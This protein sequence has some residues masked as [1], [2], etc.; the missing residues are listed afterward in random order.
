MSHEEIMSRL[1][2]RIAGGWRRTLDLLYPPSCPLCLAATAEHDALCARCW[3]A[4]PLLER[5]YCERLGL[6]FPVDLGGP[7][8][9]VEAMSNPPV[10]QRARAAVRYEGGARALAH[11]LK[12][13]D[14]TELA[15]LLA[16]MMMRAGQD[17]MRDAD[18]IVPVPLHFGRLWARRFNQAAT[19][20]AE[21][22]R[23]G[24]VPWEPLLLERRKRTRPQVGLSRAARA[25]N[26]QG[27]FAV[28]TRRAPA[29]EG[30]RVLLVDDVLTT[31]ATANACARALLR[32]GARDVD[33]LVF[34][35]VVL[36]G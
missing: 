6:P 14:R 29:L 5:P 32:A 8:L 11:R 34:A 25:D 10:F 20:S 27:A 17:L 22:S 3:S 12:Y 13:G 23:L 31:G 4:L 15:R 35:R 26:L 36:G 19:L 2:H 21:L 16:R 33:V 9:S 1:G 18:L 28:A 7:L 30:R 24:G